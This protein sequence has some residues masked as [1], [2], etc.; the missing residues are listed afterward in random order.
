MRNYNKQIWMMVWIHVLVIQAFEMKK[1]CF[2]DVL[3]ILVSE[4]LFLDLGD[5]V[6]TFPSLSLLVEK[7]RIP[8]PYFKPKA[9]G[10]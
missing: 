10:L 8:I 6:E 4:I 3:K 7:G 5:R 1:T 2:L 9:S